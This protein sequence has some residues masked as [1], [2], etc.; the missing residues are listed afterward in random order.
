MANLHLH[1]ELKN[2]ARVVVETRYG[3]VIGARSTN[4]AAVFLEVA[5]ALQPKRFQDPEPLPTHFR[6]DTKEH[7]EEASYAVQPRNDGQA[8]GTPFVDKVGFGKPTENPLFLNIIA[9]PTFPSGN[10]YP[11]RVYIHGGFLQFGSSH[12]LSSQAQYVAAE[13][14]EVWVNIGYRLSAFGFLACDNPKVDGNFGFKDQWLALDFIKDNI[15]AWEGDPND[16]QIT[17]LSAGAHSVHQI[18]HHASRLPPGH[19]APFNSAVLQ[20]NA[21]LTN[22]RTPS[23]LRPQY[24][25]LCKALGLDPDDPNTLA[26]LRDPGRTPS[27][28][29]THVIETDAVGTEF[30]TFRGCVDGKWIAES[31]DPMSWQRSGALAQGLREKGVKSVIIGDL[32]EEWYLYSIAHPVHQV[33]DIVPNLERYFSKDLVSRTI[34]LHRTLPS[35]SSQSEVQ[36]LFGEI[37]SNLQVHLP[38]RLF[39][40][41]FMKAGF[42]ILRYEIQWTPEQNRPEGYVTHGTD[43]LIWALRLPV[44]DP[45]QADIARRWLD[46]IA[47]ETRNVQHGNLSGGAA[48]ILILGKDGCL[49]WGHDGK[50]E[51]VM[52]LVEALDDNV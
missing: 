12:S 49:N 48:K 35:N 51:D 9:P 41:D 50:W 20:S 21:I 32:T 15:S 14:S 29:I 22:P 6:Y 39:A 34:Q 38:V 27:T 10:K 37:L 26:T 47:K 40:R 3:P 7:V 45:R 28:L 43:R 44:L 23:E 13:R 2:S 52:R 25:A 5:Y 36:K 16:I 24:R 31:P 1:D 33:Q 30:G 42:P 46:T 17:G 19:N 4:G 8:K 11:V 18:L